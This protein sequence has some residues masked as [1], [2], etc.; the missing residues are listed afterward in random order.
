MYI[1]SSDLKAILGLSHLCFMGKKSEAQRD[2][3]TCL[4]S[5]SEMLSYSLD[6]SLKTPNSELAL[7]V[8]FCF[9]FGSANASTLRYQKSSISAIAFGLVHTE[10]MR[11]F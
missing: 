7:F 10:Y 1:L 5:H 11:P 4:K 6:P 3:V 9:C 8:C 2:D